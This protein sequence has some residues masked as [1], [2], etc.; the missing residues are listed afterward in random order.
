VSNQTATD[1]QLPER[2]ACGSV[3]FNCVVLA[4]GRIQPLLLDPGSPE[5]HITPDRIEGGSLLIPSETETD[6][7]IEL[8]PV[9]ALF[10]SAN[11][12]VRLLPTLAG[13][14]KVGRVDFDEFGIPGDGGVHDSL[15]KPAHD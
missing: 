14:A 9:W 4:D 6:L 13:S 11:E 15:S 1:D 2:N 12:G 5:L 7:R 10:S 3:E 8:K